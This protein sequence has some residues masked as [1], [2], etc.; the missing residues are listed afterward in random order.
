MW[1]LIITCVSLLVIKA[2]MDWRRGSNFPP[3]PKG[4]PVLGNML[5]MKKL[6]KEKKY[7]AC[8]FS[9]LAEKYGPVV[10]LRLGYAKPFILV[11]GREAIV[12][13][14]SR[15]E[16]DGRPDS[17]SF[18]YRTMG[19]RRGMVFTE[20]KVWT[21]HR[22][23]AQKSLKHL[24][25]GK[26][27]MEDLILDNV[28][29]LITNL[30][31]NSK[32]GVIENFS[33]HSSISI[34]NNIWNLVGGLKLTEENA[35]LQEAV[36]MLYNLARHTSAAGGLLDHMPFL[37]FFIPE[38]SGF[39]ALK[40]C[41]GG[42]R[43]F[44]ESELARHKEIK[45]EGV[46]N[47]M[48]GAYLEEIEK[49]KNDST[50]IF[51]ELELFALIKDFFGAGLETTNNSL[52]FL[53]AYISVKPEIQKKIQEE[54]DRVFGTESLPSLDYKN[55]LPYLNAA[56]AEVLRISHVA[57]TVVPHRA[58]KDSTLFGYEIKK[59]YTL[60]A[61]LVSVHMDKEHWGDPENFRPER[62]INDKGEFIEDS[63]LM[64]FGTGRRKCIGATVAKNSLLLFTACL[65]QKFNFSLAPGEPLPCLTGINGMT[66]APPNCKLL[67]SER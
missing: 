46:H 55:N 53:I 24:G 31:R 29:S 45:A 6:L 61:N 8:A 66:T 13:M 58:L 22:R 7:F 40:K 37:R 5:D 30:R 67:L 50:S 12:E 25:F 16:F 62:F 21:D 64:P 14:L 35:K 15:P 41:H 43:K 59:D 56:I 52:G 18:R 63:W 48:I 49:R 38:Y 10:G 34:L 47:D 4:L 39:N 28:N 23:F 26:R 51:N 57:P 32:N 36:E 27:T 20:E 60:L 11:S 42:I 33:K 19:V 9:H 65:L 17:F 1:F 44:L 3:G 2:L 54:L